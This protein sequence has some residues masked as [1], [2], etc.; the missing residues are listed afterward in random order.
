MFIGKFG[1]VCVQQFVERDIL[2]PTFLAIDHLLEEGIAA[3]LGDD[4]IPCVQLRFEDGLR[5]P[6]DLDVIFVN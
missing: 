4:P 2:R 3:V 6:V 1:V 5:R